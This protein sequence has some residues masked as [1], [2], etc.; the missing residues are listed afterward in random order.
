MKSQPI[1][2]R[3]S[4]AQDRPEPESFSGQAQQ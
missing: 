4:Q 3:V 1:E 2:R